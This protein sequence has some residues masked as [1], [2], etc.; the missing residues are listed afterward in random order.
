MIE[1]PETTPTPESTDTPSE[2]TSPQR[3]TWK[4]AIAIVFAFGITAAVF[5]FRD[6]LQQLQGL[7]YLGVFLGQLISN[8][9]L[10]LP[11][12]GL[13]FV[14]LLGG[15]LNPLIVGLVAGPGA[16]IG[17]L[18][19]YAAGYGGS[20]L[21]DDNKFYQRIAGWLDR[22]GLLP[23]VL[24]ASIPNPAFD[25]A[26]VVAGSVR[27]PWWKFLIAAWI[28]K[29]IQGITIAYMGALSVGWVLQFLE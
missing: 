22:Y 29:T 7:G 15:T 28:G 9:T 21:I 1:N 2:H 27:L 16:A 13:L 5:I 4:H 10:I 11:V 14:Y 23:I 12:P 18:T 26:G 8:A 6:Q 20:A 17:E 19:G 3:F 24:L 25:M